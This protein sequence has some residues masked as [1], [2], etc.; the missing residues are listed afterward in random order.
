M[1]ITG[2]SDRTAPAGWVAR[3]AV[4]GLGV[5]IW[6]ALA[7]RNATLREAQRAAVTRA[8]LSREVRALRVA[9]VESHGLL[10]EPGQG[11][12]S[13]WK[14]RLVRVAEN[15]KLAVVGFE[16]R[17][18]DLAIGTYALDR[19]V[20][21]VR[22][23]MDQVLK[24]VSWLETSTPRLRIEHFALEP[25]LPSSVRASFTLLLPDVAGGH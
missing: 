22:G 14:D 3:A 4:F 9:A 18:S 7:A 2:S 19:R 6:F 10:P 23:T 12:A 8:Q 21:V 20:I 16:A 5:A 24:Y 13:W 17:S 15:A 1:R 11:D 25:E